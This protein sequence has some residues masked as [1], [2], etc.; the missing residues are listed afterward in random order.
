MSLPYIPYLPPEDVS[1][2]YSSSRIVPGSHWSLYHTAGL[3]HLLLQLSCRVQTIASSSKESS[4]SAKLLSYQLSSIILFLSLSSKDF[5]STFLFHILIP[6]S[7][8]PLMKKSFNFILLISCYASWANF[9]SPQIRTIYYSPHPIKKRK[10]YWQQKTR[11]KN[12][13]NVHEGVKVN[14]TIW[15]TVDRCGNKNK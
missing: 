5:Y 6:L 8:S 12:K 7:D 13:L 9:Q 1:T 15:K 4:L 3:T 11:H 14:Y 2:L 10:V